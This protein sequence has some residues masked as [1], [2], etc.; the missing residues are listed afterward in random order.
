M[1][2]KINNV[3]TYN[4]FLYGFIRDLFNMNKSFSE[5]IV[6][7]NDKYVSGGFVEKEIGYFSP[8]TLESKDIILNKQQL[9]DFSEIVSKIKNRN[10][11]L[12]LVY[13]PIPLSN[14]NRYTNNRYF[15]SIMKEYSEY[16]N[17]NEAMSLNDSIHFQD[18]HH[19][20]QKGVELFNEKLIETMKYNKARTHNTR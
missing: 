18:S 2:L 14:Y 3:R 11:E 12:I 6:K 20:N 16:Y 19:L 1:A 10:M 8:T 9:E 7:G 15:D 5:P 4:T 13:A 17:F